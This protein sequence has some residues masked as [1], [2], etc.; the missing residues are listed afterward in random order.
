MPFFRRRTF[1]LDVVSRGGIRDRFENIYRELQIFSI[2]MSETA[3]LTQ[4]EEVLEEEMGDGDG[5]KKSRGAPSQ[6]KQF[7][8]PGQVITAESGYLRYFSFMS[9]SLI[10]R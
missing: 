1:A 6:P 4:M 7:V 8:T 10:S 3:F 5:R 2:G 9:I